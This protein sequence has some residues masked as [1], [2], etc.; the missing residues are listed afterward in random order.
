M[1]GAVVGFQTRVSL[2]VSYGIF[3]RGW[4]DF[5]RPLST[6]H[7]LARKPYPER[8]PASPVSVL[9]SI[10]THQRSDWLKRH[11]EEPMS[12]LNE[13]SNRSNPEPAHHSSGVFHWLD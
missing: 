7:G 8:P 3:W 10:S 2:P 4:I 13:F 12:S 11:D 1:L 6:R 9:P 5:E